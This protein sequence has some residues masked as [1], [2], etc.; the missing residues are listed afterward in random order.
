MQ[1]RTTSM[2]QKV[3][4]KLSK[5]LGG[6]TEQLSSVAPSDA[7]SCDTTDRSTPGS[8]CSTPTSSARSSLKAA[9]GSNTRQ[10]TLQ[11]LDLGATIGIGTFSRVRI[12]KARE[13]L[14]GNERMP[15]ALKIMKKKLLIDLGRVEH[16]MDEKRLLSAVDHP[17]IVCLLAA[18]QDESRLYIC[19]EYVNGGELHSHIQK[20]GKLPPDHVRW[21]SGEIL[22]ALSYLHAQRIVYR[23]L[24]P[25][26]LLISPAGHVKLTDFGFAKVVEPGGSTYTLVGTPE[27]MAPEIIQKKGHNKGV[28]WWAFGVIVFELLTGFTPFEAQSCDEIYAK[29]LAAQVDFPQHVDAKAKDLIKR[30]LTVNPAKRLAGSQV[31]A[32]EIKKHKWYKGMNWERLLRCN[33]PPPFVPPLKSADDISMFDR[34]AESQGGE[35]DVLTE[36]QLLLFVNF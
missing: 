31:G 27:Y 10:W 8:S 29:A 19:M 33:V 17:F 21:Y 26:N 22:L 34:Y 4:R 25:S 23:D 3:L 11:D 16:V 18:F 9:A 30:L 6:K 28:D 14:D 2:L 12:A 24:K 7:G 35:Q 32:E 1:E 5:P 13:S 36:E 20:A 15:V